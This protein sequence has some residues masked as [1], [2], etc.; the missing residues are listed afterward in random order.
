MLMLIERL[1]VMPVVSLQTGA[2]L[3]D[4]DGPIIDPRQLH[5]VAFYC[6]GP[7]LAETPAVLHTDDIRE[8]S[9]L[10]LLVD[11][12][13]NIMSPSDLVRLQEIMSMHFSLEDKQVVD[14][15][16]RKVGKVA[17]FVVETNTFYVVKLNIRPSLLQGFN[18][19]E[20]VIDRT[21][22]VEITDDKIVVKAPT[23]KAAQKKVATTLNNPFRSTAQPEHSDLPPS[24][25]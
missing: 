5:I 22:I 16:G 9:N 17:S 15:T 6:R 3:A 7:R 21:Q 13:E 8:V 10:G 1:M 19:A 24:P 25:S 14:D 23:V 18:T 20:R 2:P 4:I 11:G 12:A